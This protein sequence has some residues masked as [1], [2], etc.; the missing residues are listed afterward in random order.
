MGPQGGRKSR[1]LQ[2]ERDGRLTQ[3][4]VN[5]FDL[6]REPRQTYHPMGE[7]FDKA[8]LEMIK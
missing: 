5:R 6:N 7:A 2:S 3:N 4:P 1:G 8:M